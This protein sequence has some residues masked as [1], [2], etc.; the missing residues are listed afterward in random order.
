MTPPRWPSRRR[1]RCC[2]RR[3]T[4][5]VCPMRLP[6]AS[7]LDLRFGSCSPRRHQ[8]GRRRQLVEGTRAGRWEFLK[9]IGARKDVGSF[10]RVST[11]G[12]LRVRI[13]CI[14]AWRE[15]SRCRPS[16]PQLW[17]NAAGRWLRRPLPTVQQR[18]IGVDHVFRHLRAPA[19]VTQMF[20]QVLDLRWAQFGTQP[21]RHERCV[22]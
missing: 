19:A 5:S 3:R 20:F 16:R 12:R 6:T 1:C 17:T 10:G 21:L 7:R 18:A 13:G 9:G 8:L 22:P 2:S 11:R 14:A 4:T 15:R